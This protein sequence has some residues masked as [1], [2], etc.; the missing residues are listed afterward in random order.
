MIH[1]SKGSRSRV[2]NTTTFYE[3]WEKIFGTQSKEERLREPDRLEYRESDF[4]TERQATYFQEG[5][6][7]YAE[8]RIQ[9][10]APSEDN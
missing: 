9:Y 3:N 7:Q 4:S 6:M 10:H 8:Y 5:S 1:V 2:E